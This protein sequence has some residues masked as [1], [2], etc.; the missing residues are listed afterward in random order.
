MDELLRRRMSTIGIELLSI[1][2]AKNPV[3]DEESEFTC[4]IRTHTDLKRLTVK[5]GFHQNPKDYAFH[6]S[7]HS[8]DNEQVGIGQ[9]VIREPITTSGVDLPLTR[10]VR[11]IS[12]TDQYI[13]W[14]EK[15]IKAGKRLTYKI[16]VLFEG[17]APEP[18]KPCYEQLF[19][20][21]IE[22]GSKVGFFTVLELVPSDVTKINVI[23]IVPTQPGGKKSYGDPALS[24]KN[25][26]GSVYLGDVRQ[27]SFRAETIGYF[28]SAMHQSDPAGF[29]DRLASATKKEAD[30]WISDM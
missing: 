7:S 25:E 30:T 12:R 27:V 19:E 26:F 5:F 6:L 17:Q 24:I 18:L 8:P 16:S 3:V 9:A 1:R 29:S 22:I 11:N 28:L 21:S 23:P 15:N 10:K 4:T 13:L 2:G 14:E 20:P